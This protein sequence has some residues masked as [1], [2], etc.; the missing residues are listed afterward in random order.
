MAVPGIN[1][2]LVPFLEAL[3]DGKPRQREQIK[4][5]IAQHFNLSEKDLHQRGKNSKTLVITNRMAWCDVYLCG[6][7]MVA[8]RRNNKNNMEDE[9]TINPKGLELLKTN[10]QNITV[11][12]LRKFRKS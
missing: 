7:Q 4:Q 5:H 2:M 6:S 9:F 12:Y 8:K 1:E 10:P 11:G 3:R